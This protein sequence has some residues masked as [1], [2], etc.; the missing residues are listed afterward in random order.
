[1]SNYCDFVSPVHGEPELLDRFG[2]TII[3]SAK[4]ELGNSRNEVYMPLETWFILV[5]SGSS[6]VYGW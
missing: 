1:M 2:H 6:I 4:E 3:D 5:C